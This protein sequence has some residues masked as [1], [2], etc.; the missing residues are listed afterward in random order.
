MAGGSLV[1]GANTAAHLAD[2]ARMQSEAG[3]CVNDLP[4]RF[5]DVR[6]R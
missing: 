4:R 3:L 2:I 1:D 6:K 5:A